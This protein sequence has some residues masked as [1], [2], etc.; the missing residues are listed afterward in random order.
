[1][2]EMLGK[3]SG[4]YAYILIDTP[5]VNVVADSQ[6]MNGIVSGVVFVVWEGGTTHTD[7]NKALR[8][9]EMTNGKVL[10]FIKANCNA[11]GVKSYKKSGYYKYSRK[12]PQT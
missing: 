8:S 7:I 4:H 10:G 5:P 1:M 9:V 11:K 6:L 3:L 2:R 12:K